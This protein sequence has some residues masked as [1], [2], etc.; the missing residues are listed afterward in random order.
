ME[1]RIKITPEES[2]SVEILFNR[3]TGY[4]NILGYMANYGSL[5][6]NL[7]DKKWE[8]AVNINNEL[9]ALKRELDTK[10][11]PLGA[12]SSYEFDFN[13]EEMVYTHDY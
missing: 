7:F 12:W 2:R 8:E 4:C 6:T 10:Y 3:F 5:D 9:E 11:R 13:T 1:K